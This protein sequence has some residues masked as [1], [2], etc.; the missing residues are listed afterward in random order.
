MVRPGLAEGT[1]AEREVA[2]SEEYRDYVMELLAPLGAVTPRRMFGG[3]GI[4]HDGIMF[5]LVADDT[6]FFKVDDSNRGDFEAAGASPFSYATKGGR[7][8][9]MSYYQAPAEVLEDGDEAV[10]WA[11]KAV[12]VALRAQA[13]KRR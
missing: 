11:A 4:F 1:R 3:L 7:R 10:A 13:A 5:A 2:V 9:V 6:L 8:G 12:D